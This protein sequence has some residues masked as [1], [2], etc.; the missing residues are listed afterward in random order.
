MVIQHF[1]SPVYL[2]EFE[3]L[4]HTITLLST[5]AIAVGAGPVFWTLQ[6]ETDTAS[7]LH[8]ILH[9]SL[10]EKSKASKEQLL[11]VHNLGGRRPF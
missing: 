10:E 8:Q 1:F 3:Y 11:Y 6:G 7:E 2:A 9:Q 5:E 4:L